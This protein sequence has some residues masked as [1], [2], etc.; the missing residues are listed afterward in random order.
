MSR[1]NNEIFV[2][3]GLPRSG[4]SM[5]MQMLEAAG[6]D[7][8]FDSERPVDEN[9]PRGYFEFEKVKFLGKENKWLEGIKGKAIKILFH[10]LQYLPAYLNYKIIFMKREM[11]KIIISQNKMLKSYGK[12]VSE[13]ND[14]IKSVFNKELEQIKRWL[15]EQ[16]NIDVLYIKYE[17]VLTSTN[18]IAKEVARFVNVEPAL[19]KMCK[20]VN[21]AFSSAK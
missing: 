19:E 11:D 18:D 15:N 20:I 4:T 21:P 14:H 16:E 2:V 6:M 1:I 9:N 17:D 3:S 7:L 10:Q 12:P 13:E 8:V 5:M